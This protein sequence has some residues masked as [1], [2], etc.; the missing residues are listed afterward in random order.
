[1]P[2]RQAPKE[3]PRWKRPK[4]PTGP[5]VMVN[6]K[7]NKRLT[8][9]L[10]ERQPLQPVTVQQ[11]APQLH[12]PWRFRRHVIPLIWLAALGIC[13]AIHRAQHPWYA[14]AGLTAMAAVTI[15]STRHL[16]SFPRL[17]SQ[18]SCAI[19]LVTGTLTAWLGV[20]HW[21]SW[22]ILVAW[23]APA[24]LW[25]HHY[26]WRP[27]EPK[28][29]PAGRSAAEIWAELSA[30]Q[31]WSS[32]LGAGKPIP[33][34]MQYQV[35]CRG[36][37]T[38]ID[39]IVAKPAAVA[40]AYNR[41]VTEAF[42]GADPHG[43]KSKGV[44]TM[45][46]TGTLDQTMR[47][48]PRGLDHATGLA[49]VGRFPDSEP[50]RE[51]WFTL[52]EDG[53]NHAVVAGVTGAGKTGLLNL[54]LAISA[55]SGLVCP[56]ILDPQFGQAL[57]AWR[58]HVAYACGTDECVTYLQGLE[59]AMLDRSELLGNIRWGPG[60]KRRG[61]G[62]YNPFLLAEMGYDLP[63]IEVIIDEAPLLLCIKDAL[64]IIQNIAK[65]GRKTGVR[66]KLA[67]QVPSLKEMGDQ[68]LRSMLA[69]GSVF[70]LRTGDKVSGNM[71]NINAA[72][73]DLPE[74]FRDGSKTYGIGYAHTGE[75]R[76][77]TPMRIDWLPDPYEVAE[78][79]AG[80]QLIRKMDG[81]FA[82]KMAEIM[83]QANA[84]AEQLNAEA[85]TFA[86]RQMLVLA[87][88]GTGRTRGEL[89]HA[90]HPLKLSE[91]TAAVEQLIRDGKATERGGRIVRL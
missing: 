3:T 85:N 29:A 58:E 80:C 7:P 47:W 20:V 84:T 37:R 10:H 81:R 77:D 76:P 91:V 36:T 1:M 41:P 24:A 38:H 59:A 32:W 89:I 42:V 19:T 43:I 71:L 34:G 23:A 27:A 65:L 51:R 22:F 9:Q 44:F 56:V 33:G 67:V 50:V 88:I 70:C 18:A 82:A 13:L 45:L 74:Y 69:G 52:P 15:V 53:V 11:L 31:K 64:R 66:L 48:D 78:Q 14:E 30:E 87:R 40:A 21:L 60:G 83:A 5:V 75:N 62:F 49:R 35:F 16:T 90:C 26:R 46:R 86:E 17:N 68:A 4:P 55:M 8:A 73:W 61:M 63:V 79:A 54:G 25:V 57:P 28:T 72:P 12:R 39:T 2:G 6:G